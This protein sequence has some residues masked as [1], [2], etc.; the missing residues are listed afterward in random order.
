MRTGKS[1]DRI[2][3]ANPGIG[4]PGL[5]PLLYWELP[6]SRGLGLANINV[7]ILD[8]D[9]ESGKSVFDLKTVTLRSLKLHNFKRIGTM[10]TGRRFK[11][12]QGVGP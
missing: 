9:A 11:S 6:V 2:D 12:V 7:R 10:V 4:G 3:D 8:M 5:Q 1:E